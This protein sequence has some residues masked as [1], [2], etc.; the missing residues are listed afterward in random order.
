LSAEADEL[1]LEIQN[2][3]AICQEAG[4]VRKIY[5]DYIAS[6][7]GLPTILNSKIER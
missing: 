6:T 5:K 7:L 1:R 3:Y 2:T 4:V